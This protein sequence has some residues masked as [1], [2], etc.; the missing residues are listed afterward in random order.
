MM[1]LKI[2]ELA[3]KV[4]LKID[5][6]RYYERIGLIPKPDRL[7]NEYRVYSEKYIE[8]IQFIKACKNNGF[9]LKEIEEVMTLLKDSNRDNRI[10][11]ATVSSKIDVIEQKIEALQMLKGQLEEIRDYCNLDE[12][13]TVVDF[14]NS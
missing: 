3:K 4:E 7:E 9:T 14:L 11:E 10:L 13:C 5:T 1:S 8:M 6:I 12:A 2:G